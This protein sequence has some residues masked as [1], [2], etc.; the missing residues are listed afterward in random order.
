[1]GV[2][3]DER[4]EGSSG[5]GFVLVVCVELR[6]VHE[7]ALAGVTVGVGHGVDDVDVASGHDLALELHEDVAC[8]AVGVGNADQLDVRDVLPQW[9]LAHNI[10][11]V[12]DSQTWC[13]AV[14][15]LHH[16][17]E[18][19]AAADLRL[20]AGLGDDVVLGAL[21]LGEAAGE[22]ESAV[23]VGGMD[24]WMDGVWKCLLWVSFVLLL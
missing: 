24:G 12:I 5:L 23:A 6:A 8:L 22:V 1:M 17:R 2:A 13:L 4:V 10:Q 9:A 15:G 21:P 11:S 19:A 3:P 16:K 20:P 18:G 14:S 7:A